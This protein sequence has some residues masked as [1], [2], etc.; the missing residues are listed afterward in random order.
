MN[1]FALVLRE[2]YGW[3]LDKLERWIAASSQALLLQ[4]R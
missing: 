2:N 1:G 4:D 3:S